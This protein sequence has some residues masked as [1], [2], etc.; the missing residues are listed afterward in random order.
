M[1]KRPT[2][3]IL[4]AGASCTYGLPLGAEL[5]TS[6]CRAVED[7]DDLAETLKDLADVDVE[8]TRAFAREFARSHVKSID[9]FLAKRSGFT[10]VGKLA[11][12]AKLVAKEDPTKLVN[13]NDTEHWYSYLW[14]LMIEDINHIAELRQNRI[15]FITFNYDRSLEYFLHLATKHTFGVNDATA[16]EVL[17]NF[18]I[19]HVYG[20]LGDFH[21]LPGSTVRQYFN[22]LN[23]QSLQIAANGIE[24]IPEARDDSQAFMRARDI[25]ANAENIGFLGFGFDPLNIQRLGLVDVLKWRTENRQS[26]PRIVASTL[27]V[28]HAEKA[29]YKNQICP[30]ETWEPVNDNCLMA[31]REST[32]LG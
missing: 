26:A 23:Q 11:I 8:M 2:V 19:L 15:K 1:I 7:Y 32:L 4:G 9:A 3:L 30:N 14:N 12:A 29:R 13:A 28:T 24:I 25:C 20:S 10:D 17:K 6:I 18:E 22:T 16:L 27:G 31:L 5:R 21:Y